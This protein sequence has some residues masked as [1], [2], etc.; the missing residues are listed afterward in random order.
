MQKISLTQ[1][2]YKIDTQNSNYY[3]DKQLIESIYGG[4]ANLEFTPLRKQVNLRMIP[5]L[6]VTND[7]ITNEQATRHKYNWIF[8]DQALTARSAHS[9]SYHLSLPV[10]SP[11]I[12][13]RE[14]ERRERGAQLP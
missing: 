4:G 1:H 2:R 13:S 8:K 9:T 14:R 3:N 5:L 6:Q 12:L 10:L 7:Q 11:L